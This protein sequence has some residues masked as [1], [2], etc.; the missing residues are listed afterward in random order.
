MADDVALTMLRQ[1]TLMAASVGLMVAAGVDVPDP[2]LGAL[3]T[4]MQAVGPD[5]LR[6]F[7]ASS[8]TAG[9]QS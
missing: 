4:A 9:M 2:M 5:R 6:D 8:L 7:V 3:R 1:T